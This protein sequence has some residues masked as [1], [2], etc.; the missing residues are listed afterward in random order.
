MLI[1]TTLGL[2]CSFIKRVRET[3]LTFQ[4]GNYLI[5]VFCVAVGSMADFGQLISASGTILLFVALVVYGSLLLHLLLSAVFRIDAD[6]MIITSIAA[7]FSP[8]FVPVVA[9]ALKNREIIVSGL[10][11]GIIG[12]AA[13][14]Y[15]GIAFAY[16]LK[17]LG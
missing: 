9:S 10:T 1:I 13:G 8:P 11:A 15:L 7:I 2:A 12:Y 6:T 3:R 4:L 5:L 14:N 17:S 16:F